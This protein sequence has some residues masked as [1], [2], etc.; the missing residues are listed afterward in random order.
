MK[1]RFTAVLLLIG[2]V[3]VIYQNGDGNRRTL[4]EKEMSDIS[5]ETANEAKQMQEDHN[6]KREPVEYRYLNKYAFAP[7]EGFKD[8]ENTI[9]WQDFNKDYESLLGLPPKVRYRIAICPQDSLQDYFSLED[10]HA[11]S[12]GPDK[13]I[14]CMFY[15][16]RT[17]DMKEEELEL[18][19]FEN[20]Y[21]LSICKGECGAYQVRFLQ[22]REKESYFLYPE[23]IIMQ[24]W[25]DK[26][27]YVQEITGPMPRKVM[28]FIGVD[29]RDEPL[30]IVHSTSITRDYVSEEELSF[31]GFNG[32][33]WSLVPLDLKIDYTQNMLGE[34]PEVGNVEDLNL[35]YY[36]D[37]IVFKTMAQSSFSGEVTFYLKLYGMEELEKNRSFQFKLVQ[38]S[39]A[40]VDLHLDPMGWVK[41]EIK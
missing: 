2:L 22:Y 31:W 7:D 13:G 39:L 17:I 5:K 36:P 33:F 21:E 18:L 40:L 16:E 30:V 37:G 34:E 29:D 35:I 24:T 3:I 15:D 23:H 6:G 10:S 28:N 38:E 12:S 20:G 32:N 26:Y 25:D 14:Y 8:R 11:L 19:F 1:K 4:S 9:F 41:F 27:I